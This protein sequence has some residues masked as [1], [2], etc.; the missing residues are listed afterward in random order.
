MANRKNRNTDL[1]V[2]GGTDG[3]SLF[4]TSLEDQFMYNIAEEILLNIVQSFILYYQVDEEK[5]EISNVYGEVT[6]MV[7]KN[8]LKIFSLI[9]EQPPTEEAGKFGI[10]QKKTIIVYIHK[11]RLEELSLKVES[12]DFVNY[13]GNVYEIV[14][15]IDPRFIG[16]VN[17][18][19]DTVQLTCIIPDSNQLLNI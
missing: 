15:A 10:K 16:G 13:N 2:Q 5:S 4:F 8:P 17:R 9:E 18:F 7:F 12:G 19:R 11:R 1:P 3:E 14:S 6:K